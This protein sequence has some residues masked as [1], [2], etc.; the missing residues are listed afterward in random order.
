MAPTARSTIRIT[1]SSNTAS[2][3]STAAS[4]ETS[5][6][7]PGLWRSA[8]SRISARSRVAKS[9]RVSTFRQLSYKKQD[10]AMELDSDSDRE[11]NI[12]EGSDEGKDHTDVLL[13]QR[14]RCSGPMIMTKVR[15]S[16]PGGLHTA[17]S[18]RSAI[19]IASLS[20][21]SSNTTSSRSTAASK[22]TS[23]STPGGWRSARSRV[24]KSARVSTFRQLSYKKQDNAMELDSD[25]DRE[26]NIPEGSD[27][28]Q[29]HTH[30]LLDLR[31]R[32]SGPM[33][34]TKVWM[35]RPG[36]LHTALTARSAIRITSLSRHLSN[37]TSSHSTTASKETSL[38]TPGLWRS[39]G[40]E[41][42]ESEHVPSAE[43]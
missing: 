35:S 14:N 28:G 9:A 21:H 42:S 18:A 43:L 38:S 37:T 32:C 1:S 41:V 12:P 33:V 24:M 3:H 19:G 6:S 16:R 23:P 29:D 8:R 31:D 17:P 7:T 15:M 2:S 5:L 22:E 20:R 25:S 11:A 26:A 4:K 36:G 40:H 34:M 13:D 10:S 39:A 30:V 27:E